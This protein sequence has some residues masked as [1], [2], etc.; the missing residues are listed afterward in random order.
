VRKI[1]WDGFLVEQARANA[2]NSVVPESS[3]ATVSARMVRNDA[4]LIT[5][6]EPTIVDVLGWTSEEMIGKPSTHFI[7]PEDQPSAVAAWFDMITQSGST[8]TW[9][10]RYRAA[11]G[12]WR[13]VETVNV[14]HLD[15][16]SNPVVISTIA[17]TTVELVGIEEE[18]RSR[19][20]LLAKL[21][22]ALPVGLFQIDTQRHITFTNDRLHAILGTST[23]ATVTAQ[24]TCVPADEFARLDAALSLV[25]TDQPVDDL[26]LRFQHAGAL[27]SQSRVCQ[28][29]LR[30]L[31]DHGGLVTGAIGCLHDVTDSARLRRELEI[32]ATVDALTGCLNRAATLEMLELLLAQ[33]PTGLAVV[34]IDLDQFKT[35]NDRH[36]HAA[37]DAVLVEAARRLQNAVRGDDRVGRFGGDEFIV[38]CPR[39]SSDEDALAVGRRLAAALHGPV[40]VGDRVLQLRASHGVAWTQ[41]PLAADDLIAR[42]DEA[43][44]KAKLLARTTADDR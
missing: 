4:A 24:F 21:S 16:P 37:G 39:V 6:V 20:Q 36:G 22:D 42:A 7:H 27:H 33:C 28:I 9:R 43:M 32:R 10:G 5:E 13:W 14:N 18:L 44:Y 2:V 23:A 34:F 40:A 41:T 12:G 35:I 11:D 25:L 15:D 17:R 19:K 3:D 1:Q 29:S 8:R 30:A 26:E 38:L 31:T